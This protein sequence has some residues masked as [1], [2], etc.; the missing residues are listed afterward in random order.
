MPVTDQSE[1]FAR[2]RDRLGARMYA[3]FYQIVLGVEDV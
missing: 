3:A 2:S 1:R